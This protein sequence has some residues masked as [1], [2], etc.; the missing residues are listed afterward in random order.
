MKIE[1]I[2]CR[3]ETLDRIMLDWKLNWFQ[4]RDFM[5]KSDC[6]S[7]FLLTL[8]FATFLGATLGA[9]SS[10][11]A[12]VSTMKEG[13]LVKLRMVKFDGDDGYPMYEAIDPKGPLGTAKVSLRCID[14]GYDV[15][16][17]G[18][19]VA[20]KYNELMV[21]DSEKGRVIKRKEPRANVASEKGW[22]FKFKN[23][24]ECEKAAPNMSD[25]VC[26]MTVKLSRARGLASLMEASCKN[27]PSAK[28][29]ETSGAAKPS[30]PTTR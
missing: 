29:S 8:V 16:E 24:D 28:G 2:D 17:K 18:K 9:M 19:T 30:S 7:V 25:A 4:S 13:S 12:D 10:A 1:T 23:F 5:K 3:I 14:N 20:W 21:F 15:N 6:S 11:K 26:T 22:N 27:E